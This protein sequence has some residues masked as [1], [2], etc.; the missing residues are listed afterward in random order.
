MAEERCE[1]YWGSHGC[2]KPKNHP[3]EIPHECNCCECEGPECDPACVAKT[4]YYGPDTRFYGDDV[5]NYGLKTHAD[6]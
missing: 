4:P 5:E 6:D 3:K 2:H 1:V